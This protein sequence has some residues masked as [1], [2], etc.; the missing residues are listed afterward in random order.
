VEHDRRRVLGEDR[1]VHPLGVRGGAERVRAA[2]LDRVWG[3]VE[4]GCVSS[5][6]H[7]IDL[8]LAQM[9]MAAARASRSTAVAIP[10]HT[11]LRQGAASRTRLLVDVR[12][13]ICMAAE[14]APHARAAVRSPRRSRSM[15]ASLAGWALRL[16]AALDS[17]EAARQRLP[18][19]IHRQR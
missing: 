14:R 10:Y 17:A 4:R 5:R 13:R 18:D 1:E 3:A 11:R 15:S 6:E 9:R 16:I 7:S 12:R 19:G 2:P 8:L